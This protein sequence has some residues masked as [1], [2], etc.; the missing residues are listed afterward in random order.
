MEGSLQ[1]PS[2]VPRA[3]SMI[4]VKTTNLGSA[5]ACPSTPPPPPCHP[6]SHQRA[7]WPGGWMDGSAG[8]S[9]L[10]VECERA[11]GDDGELAGAR[12]GRGSVRPLPLG[13]S[14]L[15]PLP[16]FDRDDG[17][18]GGRGTGTWRGQC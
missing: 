6:P 14:V 1:N 8:R 4:Q 13:P 9:R 11:P 5:L 3:V 15:P 7:D 12:I 17:A 2:S 18:D 16:R 10:G